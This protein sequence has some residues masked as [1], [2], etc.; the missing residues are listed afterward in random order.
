MAD[1]L[2]DEDLPRSLAGA[3]QNGGLVAQDVRDIG[4]RGRPDHEIIEYAVQRRL[5]L[6][7]A[8]I[9]F[10]NL[11][12]FPLGSHA[13]I[14]IARFPNEVSTAQLVSAIVRAVGGLADDEV[15][16]NL[17]VVEPGRVRLRRAR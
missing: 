5:T 16:G 14:V 11:L 3:L 1:F 9:G 4:L 7:T 6:L 13:G 12:R 15:V 8:D 2:V 17:I 10:G